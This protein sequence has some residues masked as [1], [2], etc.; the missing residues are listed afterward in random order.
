MARK[1]H[2]ITLRINELQPGELPVYGAYVRVSNDSDESGSHTFQTQSEFITDLLDKRHGRGNYIIEWFLDDGLSG[3][4][5]SE[6]DDTY[7]KIRPGLRDWR[8]AIR[9]G[10]LHGVIV[11]KISRMARDTYHVLDMVR[12]DI[13]PRRMDFISAREPL[14]VY[15]PSGMLVL[16]MLASAVAFQREENAEICRDAATTTLKKG[17]FVGRPG[18]GWRMETPAE[19]DARIQTSRPDGA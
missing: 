19:V 15:T 3:A 7:K 12:N 14:D 13:K 6:K 2:A 10:R 5:G 11:Y 16:T 1:R 17:F 8:K 9:S 4:F 18:Y